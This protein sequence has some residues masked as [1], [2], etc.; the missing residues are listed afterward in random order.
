MFKKLKEIF[1][2]HRNLTFVNIGIIAHFPPFLTEGGS[3]V[4][5]AHD[6]VCDKCGEK[7]RF[8]ETK[9]YNE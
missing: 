3:E 5:I 7:I 9:I 2:F 4:W 8:T 1:C 6:Y